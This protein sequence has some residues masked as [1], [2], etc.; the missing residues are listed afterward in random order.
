MS[1]IIEKSIKKDWLI[2]KA[3]KN[4]NESKKYLSSEL[5]IKRNDFFEEFTNSVK[6]QK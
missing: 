2:D 5:D 4:F 6:S 3:S 1:D